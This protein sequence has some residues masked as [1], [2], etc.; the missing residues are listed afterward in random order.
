MVDDRDLKTRHVQLELTAISRLIAHLRNV[1][2]VDDDGIDELK[3]D[4]EACFD[5]LD[6]M[7]MDV[8]LACRNIELHVD[9]LRT[10]LLPAKESGQ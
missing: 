5:Q 9:N 10:A 6:C 2:E 1:V 7:S 4:G 8:L 3:A